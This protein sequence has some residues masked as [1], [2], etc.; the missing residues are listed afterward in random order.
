MQ[1]EQS[2]LQSFTYQLFN[3]SLS[4]VSQYYAKDAVFEMRPGR[5]VSGH[6]QICLALHSCLGI[7]AE[8]SVIEVGEQQ[9]SQLKDQMVIHTTYYFASRKGPTPECLE[10][11]Y[12]LQLLK[13][14]GNGQWQCV[15]HKLLVSKDCGRW[16]DL[17]H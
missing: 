14:G 1:P 10:P 11:H 12:A 15:F 4:C 17:L 9:V 5:S 16:R 8:R 13:K 6:E 7:A 2:R 3:A